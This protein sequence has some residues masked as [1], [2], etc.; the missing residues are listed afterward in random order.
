MTADKGSI[1]AGRDVKN[2]TSIHTHNTV[3]PAESL[4]TAPRVK[5]PAGLTNVPL[6]HGFVGRDRQMKALDAAFAAS[7]EVVVQ[8]LHGLGGVGKSTLAAY[9]AATRSRSSP[10]W[11]ITAESAVAVDSGLADFAVALH[12][13]LKSMELGTDELREWALL[14]L[15]THRNWLIVLDNV[16]DQQHVRPIIER[17]GRG[18]NFLI[19]S[20]RATGWHE[21]SST[22]V[23]DALEEAEAIELFTRILN[24]QK[25]RNTDGAAE[26]CEEVGFLP[27]AVEQAASYCA[28]TGVSPR[29]YLDL[30]TSRPAEMFAATAE[31]GDANRTI[32]RIWSITLDR[33]S[34]TP[35]A[36]EA[37]R[38]LAWYAPDGIP[39]SLVDDL[40][41]PPHLRS[42]IIQL[43]SE[44]AHDANALHVRIRKVFRSYVENMADPQGLN[45]AIGRLAAYSMISQQDNT[46]TVHRLVQ[47]LARTPDRKDPHRR[48]KDIASAQRVAAKALESRLPADA[49]H[50]STW[51]IWDTLLPHVIAHTDHTPPESETAT[52]AR[53]LGE[54]SRFLYRQGAM[55]RSTAAGSRAA[56]IHERLL[57]KK[58]RV[59]L[60]S[61]DTLAAT[62][63]AAGDLKRAIPLLEAVLVDTERLLGTDHP[64]TL[65]RRNNLAG[66]YQASGDLKRAISLYESN[67]ADTERI[68]GSDHRHTLIHRNNLA[69]A[70]QAS[71]DLTHAISLY[72]SNLADT[73]RILGSDHRHTL[74]HRN[75]LARAYQEA[76]DLTHAISLYESNLADTERILGTDHPD[77]LDRRD[78]IAAAYQAGGDLTHATPLFESV[79]VDTE[80]ILG[81]DHPDTL[82]HRNNLA[83]AYQEAGDLKRAIP[84]LESNLVD[85]ERILG[86][87][88]P[89]TLIH[90]NN[91]ATAYQEAGDLERAIP[92]L[93]S[94]LVDTER[95]LGSDHPDTLRRR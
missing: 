85:T 10:R 62:Y 26:V 39:C 11:W 69:G 16:N 87:D 30:L 57:G 9:W 45:Q 31:N 63:Q 2:A 72:E 7:G 22:V 20:R 38:V 41:Y 64:H 56:Q 12:P 91:L 14:W 40:S 43:R 61:R 23:L 81:S 84:L 24:H 77:T 29:A 47:A 36:G 67:L 1:V 59:T 73:E 44:C 82:T 19:T 80:R 33:L 76:G 70:Y 92:L 83:T 35:L 34:D 71:G 78:A 37:L 94:N 42:R 18:G 65:R 17:A 4:K 28:E 25:E 49:Y 93:E 75:N 32:A 52:T 15:A 48:V 21:L 50:P 27:L 90:R 8:A 13:A 58:H 6:P 54:T 79:L 5:A 55:A 60:A 51:P 74:I 68:L 95:I 53:L 88:H 3:L 86:S 46:I 89:D 66:A